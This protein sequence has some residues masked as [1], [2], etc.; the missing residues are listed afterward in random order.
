[1]LKGILACMIFLLKNWCDGFFL[2]HFQSTKHS[3]SYSVI[4]QLCSSGQLF[5]PSAG[6]TRSHQFPRAVNW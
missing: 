2:G 5:F 4:T 6:I 1:L 3:H